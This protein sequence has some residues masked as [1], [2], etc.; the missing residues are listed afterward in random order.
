MRN[1]L[2]DRKVSLTFKRYYD[3]YF[4]AFLFCFCLNRLTIR[5]KN[6]YCCNVW[7][8]ELIQTTDGRKAKN[9][10][11]LMI[12]RNTHTHTHIWCWWHVIT[13]QKVCIKKWKGNGEMTSWMIGLRNECIAARS[14]RKSV[15]RWSLLSCILLRKFESWEIVVAESLENRD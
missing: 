4:F 8:W 3:L 1:S 10:V 6:D 5:K 13:R 7:V 9:G 11:F 12:R 2:C 14:I 15:N